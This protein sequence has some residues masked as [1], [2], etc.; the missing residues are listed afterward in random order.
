LKLA[1]LLFALLEFLDDVLVAGRGNEGREP[2]EPRNNAVLQLPGWNVAAPAAVAGHAEAAFERGL[3][4]ACKRG[5]SSVR[6][7]EILSAVVMTSWKDSLRVLNREDLQ[8]LHVA[9]SEH[10][11]GVPAVVARDANGCILIDS[12]SPESLATEVTLES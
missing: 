11:L 4:A 3:L 8:P 9:P 5:L 2:V 6:P 10:G 12:M 1:L 7:G